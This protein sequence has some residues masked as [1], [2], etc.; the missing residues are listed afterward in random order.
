MQ[1]EEI[2]YMKDIP[3]MEAVVMFCD[4]NNLE[5]E[6]VAAKLNDQII[7]SIECEAADLNLIKEKNKRL[8]F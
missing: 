8:P 5:V 2:V 6:H 7:G 3:Y 1:I 4:E